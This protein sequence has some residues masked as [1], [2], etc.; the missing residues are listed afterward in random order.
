MLELLACDLGLAIT[1]TANVTGRR[2]I[3]LTFQ[4]I[5]SSVQ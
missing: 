1:S 4:F 5:R 3:D 2:N